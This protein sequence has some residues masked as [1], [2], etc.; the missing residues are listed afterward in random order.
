MIQL[1]SETEFQG[2]VQGKLTRV[3]HVQDHRMSAI[4]GVPDLSAAVALKDYWLEL[5][6]G[7]FRLGH[8]KY[9]RFHFPSPQ[10]ARQ[11]DWLVNRQMNSR[12]ICGI[13]AYFTTGLID[14]VF[15]MPAD[16]YRTQL[17]W[18]ERCVGSVILGPHVKRFDDLVKNPDPMALVRFMDLATRPPVVRRGSAPGTA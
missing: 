6:Y 10:I 16:Q 4:P 14:Y 2:W 11:L 5:K 18:Q 12:A 17:H 7:E 13:L 15:F 3:G 1:H 8:D 9:D